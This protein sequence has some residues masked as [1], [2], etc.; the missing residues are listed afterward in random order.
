MSSFRIFALSACIC[1]TLSAQHPITARQVIDAIQKQVGAALP[2][3]TVDT[4]K[5]GNPDT[6][7][8]GIAVTMM[9]THDVLVRAAAAGDNLIITH[10]PTFYNHRDT[11]ATLES[12]SDAVLQTKQDFI[13]EHHLV[14]WRFHDGWHRRQP[15]GILTGVTRQLGWPNTQLITLPQATTLNDLAATLKSKLEI[16]VMRVV[17]DRTMKVQK[18]ALLP[19]AG[20][21]AHQVQL[22]ERPDVEV[23]VIGET[24]EWETVE[25][26]ADAA[27]EGKRKA[28]VILG[29]VRSEQPGMKE[30]AEWLHTFLPA[31]KI[32]FIAARE[33]YWA[34]VPTH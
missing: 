24:P 16:D 5:A 17:G 8:T 23:L 15:D 7:V 28:L 29:H 12:Q 18:I 20:G 4:F 21:S 27:T 11:T 31:A 25:Y 10:E 30:C 9:A 14:V 34:P 3:D 33:P 2:A 26:A 19:G 22:L 13:R 32:D 6:P 1:S